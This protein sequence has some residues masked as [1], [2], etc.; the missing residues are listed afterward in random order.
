M[1]FNIDKDRIF[2]IP[3]GA[4]LEKFN[5]YISGQEIRRR[6][7]LNNEY[8]IL[9]LGQLHGGQYVKD[10]I[11]AANL[12]L[13]HQNDTKIMIVGGGYMLE[14]IKRLALNLNM[15]D[16][17]IFTGSVS[18]DLVPQYIAAADICVAVFQDNDITRCKSPLKIAEYL[19]SGK[20]IVASDVGEVRH[21][22]LDVGMLVKPGDIRDT[23]EK[24]IR[25]L[26]NEKLRLELG[27]SARK[28]AEEKYNWKLS[29]EN[30]LN[31]YKKAISSNRGKDVICH[32][33]RI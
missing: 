16:R 15:E 21:M 28:R 7:N 1:D 32:N 9:Y 6:Y 11:E 18:H 8:L 31:A 2:R 23:A 3:V 25:L 12:V 17:I 27:I 14:E 5:P 13:Q 4:D 26:K 10:F 29:T 20:A 22:V 33:S 24:I 19:A 30:L